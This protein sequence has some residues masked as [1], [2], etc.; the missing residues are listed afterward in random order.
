MLTPADVEQKTF[1]TA[2]RGYD[3]DEVDDFL[4]EV[5]AT[6]RGLTEQLEEAQATT[7][8][9]PPP[10]P[11]PAAEVAEPEAAPE[12]EA[13]PEP[14]TPRPEI[15]E[16]AIGRALV[17][18]QTAADRLLEEAEA[19]AARIVDEAK[20][21]ADSW[22][23]EREAK[24][25]EAEAEISALTSRVAAV[26]SELA[27]L[28]SEVSQKLDDMDSVIEGSTGDT[29]P[30]TDNEGDQGDEVDEGYVESGSESWGNAPDP[31]D[32]P[33]SADPVD[34]LLDSPEETDHLDEILTGVATD[35]QL[36]SDDDYPTG[37]GDE[38]EDEDEDEDEDE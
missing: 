10:Q 3:L 37:A 38:A 2:L 16:S 19:Q 13:A 7:L 9:A 27:V 35:L 24:R 1:S 11:E 34:S 17:A 25:R 36:R 22:S 6:I 15:D 20:S 29:V 18:A 31:V 26:R 14:E 28:A 5:V 8:A 12:L 23:E 21:E 4:D 32:S 33:D 30:L